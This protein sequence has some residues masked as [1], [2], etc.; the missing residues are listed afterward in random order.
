M[1]PLSETYVGRNIDSDT[2]ATILKVGLAISTVYLVGKVVYQTL[3]WI[4]ENAKLCTI[5]APTANNPAYIKQIDIA[6]RHLQSAVF[7]ALAAYAG[8]QWMRMDSEQIGNLNWYT[9]VF[10]NAASMF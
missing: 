7:A 1:Q 2:Y 10:Y 5:K 6:G 8:I 9:L 4:A 3:A